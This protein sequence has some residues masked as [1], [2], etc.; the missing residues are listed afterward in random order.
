MDIDIDIDIEIDIDIDKSFGYNVK[1]AYVRVSVCVCVCVCVCLPFLPR[2]LAALPRWR[3]EFEADS[4]SFA[5]ALAKLPEAALEALHRAGISDCRFGA[6]LVAGE[7]DPEDVI[8][9]TVISLCGPLE[10][11]FEEGACSC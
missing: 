7:P 5:I 9:D 11:D 2:R 3:H 6:H 1:F 10:Y 4:V 8:L